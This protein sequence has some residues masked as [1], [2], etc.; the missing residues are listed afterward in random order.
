MDQLTIS[1]VFCEDIRQEQSGQ[2]TLVG[3]YPGVA[4][5]DH[6]ETEFF[7][8]WIKIDGLSPG[9]H[10]LRFKA[11]FE[12]SHGQTV[13]ADREIEVESPTEE[14]ALVLTPTGLGITPEHSG[15]LSL[16]ISIDD[17]IKASRWR[18]IAMIKLQVS[19]PLDDE[20]KEEVTL[21]DLL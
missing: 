9:P 13:F 15:S 16:S 3:V 2:F 6:G 20:E 1:A 7:A 14:S 5:V 21:E 19:P 4:F 12:D 10:Q 17:E 8:N 11:E 18:K